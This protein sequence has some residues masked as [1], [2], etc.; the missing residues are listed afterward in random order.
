MRLTAAVRDC[1]RSS[2]AARARRRR[3]MPTR[4]DRAC[5]TW[6]ATRQAARLPGP[7]QRARADRALLAEGEDRTRRPRQHLQHLR[8]HR[9]HRRLGRRGVDR[10]GQADARR[11]ERARRASRS[12]STSG[13]AASTCG[14][15]T[16]DRRDRNAQ[17]H[18]SVDYTVRVPASA[19]VDVH[20]V[21]GPS[22]V[23]GVRGSVRAET[24]SGNVDDRRH[25]EAREREDACPATSR[26]PASRPT[27]T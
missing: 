15:S 21:S 12:S 11:Q 23:T 24:V 14:P 7:Q 27:A 17:H 10:G 1:R 13:P 9:R 22:K 18:V 25:A 6:C 8:R 4:P 16:N 20:S 3:R 2:L 19:S 5:A 26:S